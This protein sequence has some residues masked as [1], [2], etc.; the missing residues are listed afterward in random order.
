MVLTAPPPAPF[1]TV[2]RPVLVVV[3]LL[4][5]FR[6]GDARATDEAD[7]YRDCVDGAAVDPLNLSWNTGSDDDLLPIL[8]MTTP[9]HDGLTATLVGRL[10]FRGSEWTWT[11]SL[12]ALSP[13]TTVDLD[14][15]PTALQAWSDD[16]EDWTSDLAVAIEVQ[17]DAGRTLHRRSA[18]ALRVVWSGD[19]VR[20]IT[21]EEAI[22]LAP[23]GAWSADARAENPSADD[24]SSS[25]EYGGDAGVES[26]GA[27]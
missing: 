18:P 23:Q 27:K 22:V 8:T 13:E 12:G 5:S 9:A 26:G 3:A 4:L 20:L 25:N 15:D 16:Q 10:R 11:Q 6:S 17:D 1:V 2:A 24:D 14:L 19:A 7:L 21:T